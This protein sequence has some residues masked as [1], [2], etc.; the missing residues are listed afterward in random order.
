MFKQRLLHLAIG[1][2]ALPTAVHAQQATEQGSGGLEEV[3]VTAERRAASLQQT[4]DAK[5]GA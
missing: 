1:L 5:G 2:V 3:V 4:A